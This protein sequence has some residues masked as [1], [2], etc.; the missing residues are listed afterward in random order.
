[1]KRS[2]H[3]FLL[4]SLVIVWMPCLALA[5]SVHDSSSK[6][7]IEI[8]SESTFVLPKEQSKLRIVNV[9]VH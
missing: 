9:V 2:V 1:M 8:Q 3:R 6:D 5:G 4:I 7:D